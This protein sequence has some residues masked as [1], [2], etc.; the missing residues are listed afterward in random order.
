MAA[1]LKF[2]AG[3]AAFA[4][5]SRYVRDLSGFLL[6]AIVDSI[7]VT[8]AR[9][10]PRLYRQDL[11]VRNVAEGC[12]VKDTTKFAL[13][14][15]YAP[16]RLPQ[17]TMN[18]AAAVIR[19]SFNLIIVTNAPLDPDTKAEFLRNCCLLIERINI[20]RDFGAYKDGISIT[21]ERFP[22][23]ERLIIANDSVMCLEK[24]IDA[25]LARLD[26]DNEF[27]GV[28]ES[29]E[30]YY[31][32]A[33][34]MLSFGP[35]IIRDPEFRKFWNHYLPISTRMWA[36]V[37]G[38]GML[39]RRLTEA[40]YQPYILFKAQDLLQKLQ[41]LT[42]P[43]RNEALGLF[44]KEFR[45]AVADAVNDPSGR[46]FTSAMM[47]EIQRRNQMHVA[48]FAFMKFLGMP[49]FKRDIIY[50]NVYTVAEAR[51]I[52][53]DL[54]MSSQKEILAELERRRPPQSANRL[55]RLLHKHGFR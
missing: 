6:A 4:R 41:E 27:I 45:N 9:L 29:F 39:T 23:I 11:R 51:Q 53:A 42:I 49:L 8:I 37:K 24:R 14:V 54:G 28:S 26:S 21:L 3:Y 32:V 40:G 30:H 46:N 52:L 25:L 35:R 7:R 34:F 43:Q 12:A 10:D 50:R 44:P 15:I 1:S 48:G 22:D 33:S 19:A 16:C 31:H 17:F 38:E 36:I 47:D 20:G 55:A 13:L 2:I 18:L 5:S